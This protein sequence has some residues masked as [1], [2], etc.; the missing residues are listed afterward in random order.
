VALD[1]RKVNQRYT[2]EELQF[3]GTEIVWLRHHI[4]SHLVGKPL[5]VVFSRRK[6]PYKNLW[7]YLHKKWYAGYIILIEKELWEI[8]L[9]V[10]DRSEMIRQAANWRLKIG[11]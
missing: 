10:N 11:K 6:I 3:L 1:N 2:P 7:E 8:P 9:F 5:F 4:K